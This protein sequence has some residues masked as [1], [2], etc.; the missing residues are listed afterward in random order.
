M[1]LP[2]VHCYAAR[3]NSQRADGNANAIPDSHCYGHE[4]ANGYPDGDIHPNFDPD[5]Y[6]YYDGYLDG[7]THLDFYADLYFYLHANLH[8][9][10][11]PDAHLN[12]YSNVNP[13]EY[14][15]PIRYAFS[16]SD[17]LS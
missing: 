5:F 7:N 12:V 6:Q 4:H 17:D 1:L 13:F 2:G 16:C 11:H 3:A 8:A 15:A 10:A 9:A 14:T